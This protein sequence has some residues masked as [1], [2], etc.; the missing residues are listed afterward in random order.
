MSQHPTV[1][2]I[3]RRTA[4]LCVLLITVGFMP[5]SAYAEL[6][7]GS[8]NIQNLGWGE[9]KRYDYLTEIAQHFELLAVQ[10]VMNAEAIERL[11]QDLEAGTG[12]R[13]GLLYSDP[14]GLNRYQEK[15]AFLWREDAV[16]FTGEALSYIDDTDRFARPPMAARFR[17]LGSDRTLVVSTLHATY[18]QRVADRIA[19]ADAMRS[20]MEWLDEV[21]ADGD[22]VLI[23]GDFNLAPS[24]PAWDTFKEIAYPAI[25]EGATTVSTVEGRYA[26]LYDQIWISREADLTLI[27]AG[28]VLVPTM[29]GINHEA[30]RRHVSDHVPVYARLDGAKPLAVATLTSPLHRAGSESTVSD[31]AGAIR[32][33]RNSQVFHR[34]DCPSYDQVAERNRVPFDSKADAKAAG[35]RL[36]GNCP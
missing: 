26:N 23:A 6:R 31:D 35:Y 1:L 18:G 29:L 24:H 32:G 25:T 12:E 3:A 36:A 17:S 10:E 2:T 14:K 21:F 27:E 9:V 4:A 28:I 16:A 5:C 30:T 34:P 7:I 11:Q 8:W 20:H 19:E 15:Y 33:N 22:P 13:W